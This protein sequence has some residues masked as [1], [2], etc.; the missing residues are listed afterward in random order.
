MNT[1]EMNTRMLFERIGEGGFWTGFTRLTGLRK[2]RGH[3][4]DI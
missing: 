3:E 1:D 4:E 2:K